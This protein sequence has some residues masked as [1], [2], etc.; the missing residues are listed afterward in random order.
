[1]GLRLRRI[2]NP[3]FV[4]TIPPPLSIGPADI[5]LGVGHVHIGGVNISLLVN[6][7]AVCTSYPVYGQEVL[8]LRPL[9]SFCVGGVSLVIHNHLLLHY[10]IIV[11][12]YV[13]RLELLA[14][15][16][17]MLLASN[18]APLQTLRLW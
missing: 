7:Q 6:D 12:F 16:K 14:T 5:V 10:C 17:D 15:R 2:F 18:P 1:M 9:H 13:G 8:L 11:H 3:F 4:A